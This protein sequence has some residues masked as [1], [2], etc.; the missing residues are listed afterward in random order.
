MVSPRG[1]T[2]PVR[3]RTRPKSAS[4]SLDLPAQFGQ[5]IPTNSPSLVEKSQPLRMLIPGR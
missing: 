1:V 4:R 3:I 5:T 2:T